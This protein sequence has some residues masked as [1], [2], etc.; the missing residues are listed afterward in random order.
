MLISKNSHRVMTLSELQLYEIHHKTMTF[1]MEWHKLLALHLVH[2][3]A[4]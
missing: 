1:A 4:G 2:Y 3:A